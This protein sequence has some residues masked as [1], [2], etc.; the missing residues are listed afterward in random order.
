MSKTLVGSL[1]PRL[2]GHVKIVLGVKY[3]TYFFVIATVGKE[4]NH[5]FN[6]LLINDAYMDHELAPISS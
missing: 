4:L 6:P 3:F 2:P 5:L 1:V